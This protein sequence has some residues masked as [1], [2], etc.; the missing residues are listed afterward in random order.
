[1][2]R[3]NHPKFTWVF[4]GVALAWASL[5]AAQARDIEHRLN[6]SQAVPAAQGRVMI[7]PQQDGNSNLIVEVQHLA[8]PTKLANPGNAYVVW[9]QPAAD[10]GQT[11]S[12]AGGSTGVVSQAT[13]AV[14][15][16]ANAVSGNASQAQNVGAIQVNEDLTGSLS[17][18]VPFS[19]FTVFVT[20]EPSPSVTQPSGDRL[21]WA[22]VAPQ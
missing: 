5:T 16:V 1:M 6:S 17:T 13:R 11:Q 8:Q 14:S 2:N 15:N 21:L 7:D 3:R 4:A 12:N 18:T 20:A 10:A 22:D 9:I 19:A